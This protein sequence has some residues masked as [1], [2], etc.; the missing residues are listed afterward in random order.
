MDEPFDQEGYDAAMALAQQ[1]VI[2][3]EEERP[4][5][6][7]RRGQGMTTVRMSGTYKT[8]GGQFR[9]VAKPPEERTRD[10]IRKRK[11]ARKRQA[12]A[13]RR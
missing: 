12:K 3:E 6:A 13:R 9:R 11:A 1:G 4:N 10:E 8:I 5:R 2:D 7:Q